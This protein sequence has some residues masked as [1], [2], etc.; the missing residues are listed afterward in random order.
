MKALSIRQ[1]WAWLIIAGIKPIENRKWATPYRGPLLIH[2]ATKH[3]WHP[4][5][6]K[7]DPELFAYGA[8]IGI[9][10]L[11]DIVHEHHSP[12]FT[13]PVGWVL[14]N[15]RRIEPINMRGQIGLF[16]VAYPASNDDA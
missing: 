14:T 16:D 7:R 8:L 4:V 12:Y 3:E 15:P 1:P 10:D 5:Y 11:V 13:G 9:V 6:Q 2:A